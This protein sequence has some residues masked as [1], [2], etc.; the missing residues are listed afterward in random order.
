MKNLW[1]YAA[2]FFAVAPVRA[3]T[4]KI[5][6]PDS[7]KTYADGEAIQHSLVWNSKTQALS[8]NIRFSNH[9]YA[10]QDEPAA[11]ESFVFHLP[12]VTFDP[13]TRELCAKGE[14]GERVVV[15]T[16]R[17]HLIGHYVN[18]AAGTVI[19]IVKHGGE[20]TVVLTADSDQ[21]PC[22]ICGHWLE[23]ESGVSLENFIHS[24]LGAA[25]K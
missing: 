14:H 9:L 17:K 19:L 15:G 6:S 12:G 10:N 23:R 5:A 1:L 2:L 7:A 20:V 13:Q 16:L 11:E 8:A 3:A 25:S 21:Q 18:P 4:V 22:G 24:W